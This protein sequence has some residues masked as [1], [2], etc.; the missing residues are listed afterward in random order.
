MSAF[1]IV[2]QGPPIEVFALMKAFTDDT[3]PQKVNLGAG[4]I[5]S[6]YIFLTV[7][8][9]ILNKT[10]FKYYNVTRNRTCLPKKL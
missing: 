7:F 10:I 8:Y 5:H 3:F 4:G 9:S 6:Y 2:E 1:D